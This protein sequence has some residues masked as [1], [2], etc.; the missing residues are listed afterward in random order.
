MTGGAER[1]TSLES[2]RF[3]V[4]ANWGQFVVLTL[5]TFWVG[6]VVGVERVVVPAL[7]ASVFHL[8]SYVVLLSFIVSFG[9]VKAVVNLVAGGAAD[10][11]GR[12]SLLIV[13]WLVALP[14]PFLLLAAPNWD[15]VVGANVLVGVNQGLA[16]SMAV[17]SKIDLAGTRQRGFAM[18][19][20]EFAGYGG[21]TAGGF[22]GGVLSSVAFR[23]TPFEFLLAVILVGLVS[24]I[25]ATRETMQFVR[26]EEGTTRRV[27]SACPRVGS[28][29]LKS[30]FVRASW[31][32]R[33]LVACS[34]AGLVEKFVDTVAWGVLPIYL[35]A[36]GLPLVS[37]GI[38]A[39]VYTGTWATLQLVFGPL[40][41]RLGR[42]WLIALGMVVAGVGV[43]GVGAS[44]TFYEEILA[45]FTAG[46][47][48]AMLYPLLLAA[49]ADL[50]MPAE[51][52]ATLGV[53]RFWR[54][55]GYG[56]GGLAIGGVADVFGFRSTFVFAGILMTVSAALFAWALRDVP[57]GAQGV[58][59]AQSLPTW[60]KQ[61]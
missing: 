43:L 35:V 59:T 29:G 31:S 14:V 60:P 40:S 54:D 47:G 44:T 18:G 8:T 39:G 9:F 34:Q 23:T 30:A 45:A 28:R 7:G 2:P 48:M 42:K 57:G 25:L 12:R 33:R 32:D 53:Y 6:A 19:L 1:S 21:V 41:D 37:V 3:G 26:H 16:W 52:G 20:N 56:F 24:A 22:A 15:W 17:T 58:P 13:G 11:I 46:V 49:V 55:S 27:A 51:R 4:K 36:Q 38:V 10:R 5:I 50:S 61:T